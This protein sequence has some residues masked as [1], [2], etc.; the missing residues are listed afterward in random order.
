V[1]VIAIAEILFGF[2]EFPSLN[3]VN[4]SIQVWSS[5]VVTLDSYNL[6]NIS[7]RVISCWMW[8]YMLSSKCQTVLFTTM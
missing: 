4:N 1:F 2:V 8:L 6:S 7:L 3:L 5:L